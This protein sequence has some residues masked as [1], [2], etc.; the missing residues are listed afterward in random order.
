[1]INAI[2][3]EIARIPFMKELVFVIFVIVAVYFANQVVEER[4]SLWFYG[5]FGAVLLYIIVIKPRTGFLIMVALL[6]LTA[7]PRIELGTFIKLSYIVSLVL[8]LVFLAQAAVKKELKISRTPLDVSLFFLFLVTGLSIFQSRYIGEPQYVIRSSWFNEPYNRSIFQFLAL[9]SMMIPYYLTLSYI[10]SEKMVKKV[11]KVWTYAAFLVS[12]FGIYGFIGHYLHLPFAEYAVVLEFGEEKIPRIRSTCEEPIFL[13]LFLMTIIPVLSAILFSKRKEF[14][15]KNML[16]M[17]VT[18]MVCLVLT[19]SRSAWISCIPAF[20]FIVYQYRSVISRNLVKF[21]MAVGGFLLFLILLDMMVFRG[22]LYNYAVMRSTGV[23]TGEEF[24]SF[25]RW[26]SIYVAFN[27]FLVHPVLGVGIGN[28]NFH[29]MDYVPLQHF[30]FFIAYGGFF[31]PPTVGNLFMGFLAEMGILGFITLIWLFIA[32]FKS[33][34]KALKAS[35][36]SRWN[37]LLVGG[38]AS[39]IALIVNYQ[40]IST[41]TFCYVWILFGFIV[42]IQKLALKKDDLT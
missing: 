28:F 37:P 41:F 10:D 16:P 11:I 35:W 5:I 40:F 29:F 24:S 3:K 13:G 31:S 12:L 32:I 34:F 14:Y 25:T 7:Y 36:D 18:M 21:I 27:L 8:F 4:I 15:F 20:L 6:P 30:I 1:M 23:L 39:I 17:L 33:S 38:I 9:L 19:F 42:A 2:R 26:E 22:A